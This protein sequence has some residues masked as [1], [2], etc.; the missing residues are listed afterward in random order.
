VLLVVVSPGSTR[1]ECYVPRELAT[2]HRLHGERATIMPIEISAALVGAEPDHAALAAALLAAGDPVRSKDAV[3]T[4]SKGP[5]PELVVA[6]I[7][8][9][10]FTRRSPPPCG[11]RSSCSGRVGPCLD[12]LRSLE[13]G[14]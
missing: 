8:A 11:P 2:F 1:P 14:R 9:F 6:L 4:L 12:G 5:S 3:E 7:A 10:Q 13:R